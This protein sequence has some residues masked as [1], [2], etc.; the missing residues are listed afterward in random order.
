MA[1]NEELGFDF[2]GLQDEQAQAQPVVTPETEKQNLAMLQLKKRE[3]PKLTKLRE[4]KARG[5]TKKRKSRK[6]K[7]SRKTR[8]NR[9]RR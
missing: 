1:A 8:K 3:D 7:K 6:G 4:K 9:H 2:D 5:G